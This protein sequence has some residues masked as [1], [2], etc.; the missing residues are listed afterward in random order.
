MI[1]GTLAG[2]AVPE[3]DGKSEEDEDADDYAG[4]DGAGLAVVAAVFCGC[5][6][7]GPGLRVLGR[8]GRGE[9]GWRNEG[10]YGKWVIGGYSR[11]G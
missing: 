1:V 9:R 3:E 5:G 6:V 11:W 10:C 2:F 7:G 4:G 8:H